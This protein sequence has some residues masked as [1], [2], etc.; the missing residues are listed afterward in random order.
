MRWLIGFLAVL[1][2]AVV[3]ALV[4]GAFAALVVSHEEPIMV[5]LT[6]LVAVGTLLL[7]GLTL[8]SVRSNR[9]IEWFTGALERHSDQMRQLAA[10]QAKV[11]LIWWDK[12][13]EGAGGKFPFAGKH[14]QEY[15]L[16]ALHIGIPPEYRKVQPTA[17]QRFW[18]AR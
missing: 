12:T 10:K 17:W 14:N 5:V 3:G 16:D 2:A 8:L 4:G 1:F 6:A 13:E 18:G 9:R 7:V 15:E 11:K